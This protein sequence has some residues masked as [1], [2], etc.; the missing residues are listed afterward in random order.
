MSR[1]DGASMELSIICVNWNSVDYLREC[2]TS[3]YQATREVFFEVVVVDNASPNGDVDTLKEVFPKIQIIKCNRIS[4][5]P[6]LIML[7][8]GAL[9]AATCYS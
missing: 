5:L 7:A 4:G 2:L 8:P 9:R 6:E 3:I 1:F